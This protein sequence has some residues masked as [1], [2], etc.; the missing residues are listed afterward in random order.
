MEERDVYACISKHLSEYQLLWMTWDDIV[1]DE[2]L[3]EKL[4]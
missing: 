2:D 4:H 1:M 3:V